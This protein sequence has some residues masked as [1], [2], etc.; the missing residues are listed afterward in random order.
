MPRVGRRAVVRG[1]LAAAATTVIPLPLRAAGVPV[2]R[3]GVISD[4]HQDIIP[5][6]ADRITAF[7]AAMT[8][9][10]ADFVVELGDFCIPKSFDAQIRQ[11][12]C[13][14]RT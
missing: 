4:V 2:T 10:R 14:L 5:D 3:F 12:I 1:F 6:A 7:V 9:A 13:A 8:K 11:R